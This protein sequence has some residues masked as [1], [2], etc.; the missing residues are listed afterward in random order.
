MLNERV[1]PVLGWTL[2]AVLAYACLLTIRPFFVPLAWA[3]V[4]ATVFYPR[5]GR[6]EPNWGAARSAAG[7]TVVATILVAGPLFIISTLF[8]REAVQAAA[9]LQAALDDGRYA[10]AQ[11]AIDAIQQRI[12]LVERVDIAAVTAEG[13]KRGAM[14][15]ASQSGAVVRNVGGF[16]VDLVVALFA[17]FF[18]LRDGRTVMRV[19]RHVLPMDVNARERLIVQVRQLV[20]VSVTSS[21]LVA[22]LQGFLGGAVFAIAGISAPVFWGVVIALFCLLPLGA[23]LIWLPAALLLA[24]DGAVARAA[25]VAGLG[26]C[27]ISAV[28]NVLRPAL[29][30]GGAQMNGLVIL[31]ALLGGISAFGVVGVVIGPIVLATAIGLLDAYSAG[32]TT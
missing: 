28:D 9:A 14:L 1:G 31:I 16:V 25:L 30:S 27:V 32:E 15:V 17:T 20:S 2:L 23:W 22:A 12:R 11:H 13:V 19:V 18:L 5:F 21:L 3:A 10:W 8:V 29:L 7:V 26:F 6:L 24:L 4:L